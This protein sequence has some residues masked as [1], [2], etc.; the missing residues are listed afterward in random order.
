MSVLDFIRG[1]GFSRKAS[2][3]GQV[4]SAHNVGQPVWTDRRYDLLAQEAYR[5]NAVAF[6]C[7]SMIASSAAY[8]PM[9]LFSGDDEVEAHPILD[10]LARPA[11]NRGGNAFFEALYTHLLIAGNAYI[12]AVGPE[13]RPPKEL[14]TL[15]PDRVR[16][17]AGGYG[18][19]SAFEYEANGQK[20][21]WDV[22][23]LT[24]FGDVL[25]LKEFSPIDDWYGQP[26][27]DP[28]AYAI[29]IHNAAGGHNKALLDN[30][31]RPSGAIVFEPVK[32]ADGDVAAPAL[33][34]Q[35]AE[36]LLEE[37]HAGRKNAGRPFVF[38]GNVK[39]EQMGL[40]PKDLDFNS[41]KLEAAREICTAFG[42]PH[43]LL[44][45]GQSTYNNLAEAK[46]AFYEETV[47]PLVD[48]VLDDI[49]VWLLPRYGDGL[50]LSVDLDAISALEPRRAERRQSVV[51]LLDKRVITRTEAREML[52]YDPID[53]SAPFDPP[54][55]VLRVL[56]AARLQGDISR[57]AFLD[58]LAHWGVLAPGHNAD[59]DAERLDDELAELVPVSPNNGDD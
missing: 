31:C 51:E 41:G 6:R 35:Q 25:H 26:R 3:A 22:D 57:G 36:K 39:W 34:I 45:P 58:A 56:S 9:L 33:V 5:K 43:I 54:P 55:E 7:I 1:L 48:K 46:L 24:G 29:D 49:N 21:R 2:G 8:C 40:T 23:P 59:D 19:P 13:N 16:V 32:G 28:A 50:Q 38:G 30:G 52:S 18:V 47:L 15:R 27:V 20:K 11:P 4:I 42:V 10:L 44:I 12:E 53:G 14:W 37:R 17:I